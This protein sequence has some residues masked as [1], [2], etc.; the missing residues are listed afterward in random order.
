MCAWP[1]TKRPGVPSLR[2]PT[3]ANSVNR[4]EGHEDSNYLRFGFQLHGVLR[5]EY[6]C[7][8]TLGRLPL[9]HETRRAGHSEDTAMVRY[10][11][12]QILIV[13]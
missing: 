8:N 5:A 3:Q 6:A 2:Q 13:T 7:G 9:S 1:A 12:C 10:F 11:P 4:D